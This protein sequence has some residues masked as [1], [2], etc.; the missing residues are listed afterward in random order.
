MKTL[1]LKIRMGYPYGLTQ[2]YQKT[3]P[4]EKCDRT[5]KH[6]LMNEHDLMK[7][8][9]LTKGHIFKINMKSRIFSI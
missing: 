4:Y 5:N 1:L 2:F 8:H 3:Y 6:V 7:S 9:I